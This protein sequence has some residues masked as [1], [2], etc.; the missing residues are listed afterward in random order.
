MWVSD[1]TQPNWNNNW[2]IDS[3]NHGNVQPNPTEIIKN[4]DIKCSGTTRS[5][6]N[7]NQAPGTLK[8]KKYISFIDR[9]NH[10]KNTFKRE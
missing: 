6:N 7:L 5:W 4:V 2:L 8:I 10:R 1:L 3:R 9:Q